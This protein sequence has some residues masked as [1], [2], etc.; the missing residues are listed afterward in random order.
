VTWSTFSHIYATDQPMARSFA[1]NFSLPVLLI[2][3][4]IVLRFFPV[5]PEKKW[6][7][8]TIWTVNDNII[9]E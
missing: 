2:V 6:R 3:G 5:Q 4:A 8:L 9:R 1:F 7:G